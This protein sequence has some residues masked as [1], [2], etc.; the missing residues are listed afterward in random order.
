[1]SE[2]SKIYMLCMLERKNIQYLRLFIG[3][4]LFLLIGPFSV[5]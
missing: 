2:A 3:L 4:S 5:S 1:M